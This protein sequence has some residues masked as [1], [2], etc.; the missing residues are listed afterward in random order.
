MKQKKF[1]ECPKKRKKKK[2]E[3]KNT[4]PICDEL[5]VCFLVQKKKNQKFQC[6]HLINYVI[7]TTQFLCTYTKF[8]FRKCSIHHI[9]SKLGLVGT[10]L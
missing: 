1:N 6:I 5:T 10:S 4:I 3:E 8:S 7:D 2:L 9:H